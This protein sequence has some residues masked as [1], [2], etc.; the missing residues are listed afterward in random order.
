MADS[1][2]VFSVE[3]LDAFAEKIRT[4]RSGLLKEIENLEVELRRV[5]NW[6]EK[7]AQEYWHS[8]SV[9]I[10]RQLSEYLQALS[11]CM[12]YVREDERRP[13]TEEKKR[14]AK[15]KQRDELCQIKLRATHAAQ[16]VWERESHKNRAKLQRCRD[17]AESDLVV[18][19]NTLQAQLERL[20]HYA[21]LRSP[22]SR[23]GTPP[24]SAP[25]RTNPDHEES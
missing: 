16:G 1:A 20:E 11:R 2:K 3:A 13:C 21:N 17:M 14:V 19:V 10:K 4:F 6:L 18:A 15:A 5:S 7:D 8:E 23:T 12:S 25:E 9:Q 24:P 22:A